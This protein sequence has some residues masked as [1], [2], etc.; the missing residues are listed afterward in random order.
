MSMYGFTI[1]LSRK[2]LVNLGKE[3]CTMYEQASGNKTE[4]NKLI[5]ENN[6]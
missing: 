4:I 6:A 2:D 3:R 1:L 5:G